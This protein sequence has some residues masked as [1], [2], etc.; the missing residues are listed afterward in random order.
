MP[1]KD[2]DKIVRELSSGED[3]DAGDSLNVQ[4]VA[5]NAR[6]VVELMNATVPGLDPRDGGELP[7]GMSTKNQSQTM[8][9]GGLVAASVASS[10]RSRGASSGAASTSGYEKRTPPPSK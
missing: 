8:L 1:A 7:M 10:P 4:S 5:R 9:T 3:S 2:W 6:R